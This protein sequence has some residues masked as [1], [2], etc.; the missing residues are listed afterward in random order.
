[1]NE[2]I[3]LVEILKDCPKGMELDCTIFNGVAT[4]EGLREDKTNYPIKIQIDNNMEFFDCYGCF[5]SRPYAKCVIFPKGKTTW[6]GFV[7]PC[8]FKTGDVLVSTGGNIV[9]FSHIDSKDIVHYHCII[10][11][12]GS[13]RIEENTHI[14][15]GRYYD[16]VLANEQQRQRM[17]D[18]I[19]C[20]GY[21]YNQFINKLEKIN[22]KF[23]DGDIV[24]T[25]DGKYIAIIKNNDGKYYACCHLN[26]NYFHIDQSG[27]FDR[28][29]TEE[30]K[31][32]LFQIIKDKGYK[33]NDQI[34]KLEVLITPNFKVGNII[35]DKDSYKVKITAV[36][37]EDKFYEYESVIAKGIGTITFND[38]YDWNLVEYQV[39]DHFIHPTDPKL[40]VITE[41]R[42]YGNYR[43]QNFRG[44]SYI[45]N[46]HNL[47]E[48]LRVSK[49]NPKWFKPFDKVLVRDSQYDS[50]VATLFSHIGNNE[51]YPYIA[52]CT[53]FKYCIPYNVET[54]HLVGTTLE[55]PEFYKI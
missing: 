33:W 45:I 26:S 32:K 40:F 21:K 6:E 9:L 43:I 53:K 52:S 25:Y 2:N 55:E 18:K 49:W 4:F 17:Y 8:K 47:H 30:E 13:F 15:V 20:S 28:L 44:S 7:P 37:T 12:Y 34:K 11:T 39:G 48:Y 3:N 38:Q 36:N 16:C 35:Q 41:I 31:Q 42:G 46:E 54:K 22:P 10:P 14:G 50:W 1:M 51:I 29:A 23:E 27:W 5:S 24:A 19:K